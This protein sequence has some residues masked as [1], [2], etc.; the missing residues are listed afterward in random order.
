M[1]FLSRAAGL[2]NKGARNEPGNRVRGVLDAW[3]VNRTESVN[4]R[5]AATYGSQQGACHSYAIE[6]DGRWA[7]AEETTGK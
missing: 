6:P 4:W 7:G 5:E 2:V 3:K 1:E